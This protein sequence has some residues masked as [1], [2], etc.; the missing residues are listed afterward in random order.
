[1]AACSACGEELDELRQASMVLSAALPILDTGRR[2]SQS[3]FAAPIRRKTK[4]FQVALPRAAVLLLS[5]G[6]V[7]AAAA[8]GSPVRAWIEARISLTPTAVDGGRVDPAS[9]SASREEPIVQSGVSVEP[10]GGRLRIVL[11]RPT[12][13]LRI[14]AII[15]EAARGGAYAIGD[16]AQAHFRTSAGEVEVIDASG[17]ELRLEIPSGAASATVELDGRLY[18]T[19]EGDQLRLLV[20]SDDTARTEVLFQPR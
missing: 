7:A 17:G 8:P 5:F 14:R 20:A 12:S 10:S 2:P 15:V 13:D 9:L 16:S 3:V 1:V 4:W 19:K 6:A 18:L 11:T